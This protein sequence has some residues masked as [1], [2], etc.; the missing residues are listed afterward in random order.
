MKGVQA[1]WKISKEGS[2]CPLADEKS[3]IASGTFTATTAHSGSL[4]SLG[5]I[6]TSLSGVKKAAKLNVSIT[7]PGT[8]YQN[9]WPIWVYPNIPDAGIQNPEPDDS[10]TASIT[11][12]A[13]EAT[14]LLA[15]VRR[16]LPNTPHA[17]PQR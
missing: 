16:V 1:K 9:E 10:R 3:V 4:T 17:E 13:K 8:D 5:S 6:R 11:R 7:I 14:N 12:S 15:E 2:S